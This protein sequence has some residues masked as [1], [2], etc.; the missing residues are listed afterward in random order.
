MDH[1]PPDSTRIQTLIDAHF[2]GGATSEYFHPKILV[3]TMEA[4][5][6]RP[7][8]QPPCSQGE[9]DRLTRWRTRVMECI[10]ERLRDFSTETASQR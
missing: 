2:P 3:Y 8:L 5:N 4:T 10:H 6:A 7:I 9:H 1:V